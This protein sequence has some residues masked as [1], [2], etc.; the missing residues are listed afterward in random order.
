MSAEELQYVLALQHIP[1]LGDPLAKKL[2]RHF[3]SAKNVLEQK[4]QT[5]LKIDGIGVSR[6]KD[7]FDASH[8]KAA[9]QELNFIEKNNIETLYFKDE[10]YPEKL[11]HCIDGPV[12]L[13]QRG[14]INLKNQRII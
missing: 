10:N 9:E 2:I 8:L 4:K 3:W 12:L 1:T 14:N 5:L 6:L 11:K 13:F 7:F